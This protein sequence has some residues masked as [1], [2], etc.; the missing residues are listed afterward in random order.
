MAHEKGHDRDRSDLERLGANAGAVAGKAVDFGVEVTG[1]F[2]RSAAE[3]LGGWWSGEGPL[4]AAE[5][6]TDTAERDCRHHYERTRA[7]TGDAQDGV[8]AA[9]VTNAAPKSASAAM[10]ADPS[11]VSAS[12]QAGDAAV[13]GGVRAD[14]SGADDYERAR[15]GYRLG[16]VAKQNPAYRDRSFEQVEPELRDVWERRASTVAAGEDEGDGSIGLWPDVRGYVGYAFD[17]ED[18]RR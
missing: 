8:G 9:H 16:W 4:R 13:S 1:A 11:G 15:A 10:R 17:R 5:S 14:D 7:A 2:V 6:W 12:A 3:L 18:P